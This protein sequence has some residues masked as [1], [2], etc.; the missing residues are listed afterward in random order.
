[1]V[2]ILKAVQWQALVKIVINL[3]VSYMQK[4]P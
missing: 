2:I 1:M 4:I 3:L